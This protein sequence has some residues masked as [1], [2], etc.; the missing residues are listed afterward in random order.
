MPVCG[1]REAREPEE[2][3]GRLGMRPGAYRSAVWED[4]QSCTDHM[5]VPRV[6][7]SAQHPQPRRLHPAEPAPNS[8]GEAG[9]AAAFAVASWRT[10]QSH[11]CPRKS[12]TPQARAR[13][14]CSSST[15][16]R[17]SARSTTP[18][19][20]IAPAVSS[21]RSSSTS[22]SAAQAWARGRFI[23][24][25]PAT[26][27]LPGAAMQPGAP[28][29]ISC[30]ACTFPQSPPAR[31]ATIRAG[32][33]LT[34]CRPLPDQRPAACT[35]LLDR[36]VTALLA[37]LVFAALRRGITTPLQRLDTNARA[38]PGCDLDRP[39]PPGAGAAQKSHPE[40]S[41]ASS[42]ICSC[43]TCRPPRR[44]PPSA[45]G[46]RT[47]GDRPDR[48]VR[49]AGGL[50][51]NDRGGSGLPRQGR[52]GSRT[53]APYGPLRRLREP[54]QAHDS[55]SSVGPAAGGQKPLQNADVCPVPSSIDTTPGAQRRKTHRRTDRC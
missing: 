51:S 48:P 37:G 5:R 25:V 45:D 30:A 13:N 20:L 27:R 42:S 29:G 3:T 6:L 33:C 24:C 22:A 31:P 2:H 41:I 46:P 47:R 8:P 32:H 26:R 17:S 14:A 4:E 23:T 12:R 10:G 44:P 39:I 52:G 18:S 9:S 7:R 55:R 38:I 36:A 40:H 11:S 34:R 21:P 50:R 1:E 35:K 54:H 43:P 16:A 28:H 19:A 15:S 53:A 49:E